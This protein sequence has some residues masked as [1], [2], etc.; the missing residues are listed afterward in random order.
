M[1]AILDA[2]DADASQSQIAAIDPV[3]AAVFNDAYNATSI[4]WTLSTLITI[5]SL[6]KYCDQRP[7]FDRLDT[8]ENSFSEKLLFPRD[9]LGLTIVMRNLTT[10][11]VVLA[12]LS[13]GMQRA[14]E[15]GVKKAW[16]RACSES[17]WEEYIVVLTK[18]RVTRYA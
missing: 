12:I 11:V 16:L 10:H 13:E 4:E 6:A 15:N 2:L 3:L 18:Q 9:R 1:V 14:P 7:E 17:Q 8:V 5:L